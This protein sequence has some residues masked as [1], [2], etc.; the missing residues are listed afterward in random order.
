MSVVNAGNIEI[1]DSSASAGW[2][3]VASYDDY[4]DAQR[5][6]DRLSDA[7]FPVENVEIVGRGLR[8]VERVTGR[9]TIGRATAAGA[10]AG[11]WWGLLVGLLVGLFATGS[12]W[13][14]LMLGGLAIGAAWGAIFG[15]VAQWATRGRRDFSSLR[16]LA[17]REYDLM[18]PRAKSDSARGVLADAS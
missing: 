4:D 13:V 10:A 8:F 14:W 15:F 11:A 7:S 5:A 6:V 1:S 2:T 18:V 12:E 9:L 16:S 17:A 3:A